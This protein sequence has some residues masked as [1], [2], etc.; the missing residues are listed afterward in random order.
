MI[1]LIDALEVI[2]F[3]FFSSCTILYCGCDK[4]LGTAHSILKFPFAQDTVD[5]LGDSRRD[6]DRYRR[7]RD[8]NHN[9]EAI[10]AKIY[11][12]LDLTRNHKLEV[13]FIAFYRKEE[14]QPELKI[15]HLWTIYH[16]DEKVSH[17]SYKILCSVT[18]KIPNLFLSK[19]FICS[20]SL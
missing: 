5:D 14:V 7:D 9:R 18:I 3:F 1:I 15:H 16:Y 13:P 2:F 17:F 8:S 4:S 11:N 19:L 6:R 12:A 10:I 20:D